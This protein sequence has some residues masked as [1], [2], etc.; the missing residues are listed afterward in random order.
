[1]WPPKVERNA[2]RW[3]TNMRLSARSLLIGFRRQSFHSFR[4]SFR[5]RFVI[6]AICFGPISA[7]MSLEKAVAKNAS[8]HA[9]SPSSHYVLSRSGKLRVQALRCREQADG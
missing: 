2:D 8:C 4:M 5:L 1:V 6:C 9:P 7:K 3:R